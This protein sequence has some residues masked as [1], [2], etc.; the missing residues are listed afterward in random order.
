MLAAHLIDVAITA[1]AFEFRGKIVPDVPRSPIARSGMGCHSLSSVEANTASASETCG[2]A[3]C[4][5]STCRD[6]RG[7]VMAQP[8]AEKSGVQGVPAW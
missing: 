1:A 4:S 5:R 8:R 6:M 2:Q 7:G 3:A